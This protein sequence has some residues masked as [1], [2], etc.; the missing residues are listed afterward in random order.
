MN[1]SLKNERL[2][3]K[4]KML[5]AKN[6]SLTKTA[7]YIGYVVQAICVNFAPML[8]VTFMSEF[9]LSVEQLSL[10][11]TVTFTVQFTVDFLSV[12]LVRKISYRV[13]VCTAHALS[14]IGLCS[15]AVL[16]SVIYPTAAL[17]LS[18]IV[19]SAGSGLI[20][21]VI[22]PIIESC[23][24][25][26]KAA[27]MSFLHSFYS[28]GQ[29]L[30]VLL[31]TVFFVA[32]GVE[33]WRALSLIW[34]AV[35]TV[36]FVLFLVCPLNIEEQAERS[37]S[38]GH[39]FKNADF[40]ILMLIIMCSG[41]A[42]I[43]VSQ[44]ASAYCE[45]GLGVSKTVGD[46]AGPC[47]FAVCMGI[48]RLGYALLGERL[49]LRYAML[50]SGALCLLGYLIIALSPVAVIGLCGFAVCGF[51]VGVLWPGAFS[52]AS[53]YVDGGGTMFALL[54]FSGDAGCT[55]GPTLAGFM[56]AMRA[57]DIRF[58]I[59]CAGVFPVILTLA[60]A[61][62]CVRISKRKRTAVKQ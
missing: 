15:L 56:A 19:Y 4:T 40:L 57:D 18:V 30:T 33:E 48:S 60:L 54:S 39:L 5:Q 13:L 59:S 35:P 44:W 50:A 31:S 28:W 14:A 42:E 46:I 6:Y 41:A 12:F 55:L 11:I 8:F 62:L 52:L 61:F 47:A 53:K 10:L 20:E 37:A 27:Q 7:A 34:A 25:K 24:S 16:P 22:S 23:P 21:V 2:Y 43:A 3:K 49:K 9:D 58:G 1:F 17:V 51:A 26:N 36:N 38:V 29:V 45:T 32:F